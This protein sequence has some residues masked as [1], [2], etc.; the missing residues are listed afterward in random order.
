MC[1]RDRPHPLAHR[2]D[3]ILAL[4]VAKL[5]DVAFVLLLDM[6]EHMCHGVLREGHVRLQLAEPT[7]E[8]PVL[9]QF[10][11]LQWGSPLLV[12]AVGRVLQPGSASHEGGHN[13]YDMAD[14]AR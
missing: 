14:L 1:I 10:R 13:I 5:E 7:D 9:Q 4:V 2:D 3:P 6:P 12:I 11:D 8:S